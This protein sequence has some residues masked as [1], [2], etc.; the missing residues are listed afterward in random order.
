M[1]GLQPDAAGARPAGSTSNTEATDVNP[2]RDDE[3]TPDPLSPACP[4]ARLDRAT[5]RLVAIER[6]ARLALFGTDVFREELA[7]VTRE[8]LDIQAGQ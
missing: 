7:A 2:F 8:F 6:R 1:P 4:A 5:A 3:R